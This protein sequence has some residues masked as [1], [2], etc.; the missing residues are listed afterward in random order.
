MKNHP[1]STVLCVYNS[2]STSPKP[3][4]PLEICLNQTHSV[5]LSIANV[6]CQPCPL[7]NSWAILWTSCMYEFDHIIS[8]EL[9]TRKRVKV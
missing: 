8:S 7:S 2:Y 5:V 9:A 1:D 4:V 6:I 3:G